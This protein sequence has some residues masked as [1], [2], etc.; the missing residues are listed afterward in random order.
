M[1]FYWIQSAYDFCEM[2][3]KHWDHPSVYPMVLKLLVTRGNI[4]IIPMEATEEEENYIIGH[5]ENQKKRSDK[6]QN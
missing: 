4:T 3:S 5:R 6:Y 1:D 2:I